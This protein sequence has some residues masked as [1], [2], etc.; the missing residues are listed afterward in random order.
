MQ[1]SANP[2][3]SRCRT[4]PVEDSARAGPSQCRTQPIQDSTSRGL[5]QSRTQCR[6]QPARLNQCRTQPVQDSVQDL[7]S[8]GL[9]QQDS[10]Q[11]LDN[12][13]LIQCRVMS[14]SAQHIVAR[15]ELAQHMVARCELAVRSLTAPFF[16]QID[17]LLSTA[18]KWLQNPLCKQEAST[19]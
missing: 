10:V 12:P 1:D 17:L 6:T 15:C 18:L 8:T 2:E 19:G 13:G 11:D 5:S 3:L 16:F 9:N 7:A 4:Q 14:I